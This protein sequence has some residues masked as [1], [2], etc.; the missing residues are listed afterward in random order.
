[1][2]HWI[3][4]GISTLL[5][6]GAAQAAD[7]LA[8]PGAQ[9]FGALATGG[10]GGEVYH[11]TN[12][13]DTGPGSFRDAV[14]QPNRTIVFDVGGIV[15]LNSQVKCS[16][17]L[18]IAG[19][20]APG[21]GI[22][23]LGHGISFSGQRNVIV[24]Y[25]RVRAGIGSGRGSKVLNVTGD[26]SGN[27][28]F[29]H[30]SISWGRWDNL[31]FTDHVDHITLQH[32][33]IGEAIDPQRFGALIDSSDNISVIGNLWINHSSRNPKGKAQMQ[34]I[35]NV[36]YNWGGTGYA[37]GHSAAEWKADLI[38]NYFIKG[39][40]SN[41]TYAGGFDKT[42]IVYLSGNLVD[43]DCDGK[44]N[45]RPTKDEEMKAMGEKYTPPTI[46]QEASNKPAI[47]V[48]VLSPEAA[49]QQ[50]VKTG[51][52]SQFRDKTDQRLIEQL[53]SLGTKGQIIKTEEEV[54]G[55]GELKESKA[56]A[57]TDR[58]GI[59]DSYESKNGLNPNDAKDGNT[60]TKDGY[61]NL[62]VYLNQIVKE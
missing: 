62:E 43:L 19:Q 12:L 29:D 20:T 56:E 13:D 11:V 4:C 22:T 59:P 53:T 17:N 50:I 3:A 7:V 31:G 41:N 9:G 21:E 30:M 36:V 26:G 55:A 24:R 32:C 46:V 33:L 54:G 5:L 47:E 48:K 49:Y 28:I 45:G 15:K 58:D 6:T 2:K 23:L 40:N 39:P 27:M 10:R 14:S 1:M 44:L 61:T 51:G 57:D 8:F 34:Y 37:G 38:N 16:G 52:A 35:N 42:D 18:T 60:L 25:L